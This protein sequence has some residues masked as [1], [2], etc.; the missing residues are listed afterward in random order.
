MTN[1]DIIAKNPAK[2]NLD[3]GRLGRH[4]LVRFSDASGSM[5]TN[6]VARMTPAANDL[7]AVNRLPSVARKLFRRPS[8]GMVIPVAPAT[9]IEAIATSFRFSAAESSRHNSDESELQDMGSWN[10]WIRVP[11]FYMEELK[12]IRL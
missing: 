9:M 1:A 4:S 2:G 3:Q 10:C 11:Q 7:A 6:P 8:K 5:C 12:K